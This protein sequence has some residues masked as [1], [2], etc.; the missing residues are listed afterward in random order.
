MSTALA[1]RGTVLNVDAAHGVLV[2]DVKTDAGEV[3]V[4]AGTYTTAHGGSITFNAD[5]S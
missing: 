1:E 2:N 4:V 5:G 3:R